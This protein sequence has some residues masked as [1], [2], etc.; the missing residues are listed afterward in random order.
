MFKRV[1]FDNMKSGYTLIQT[2]AGNK[3]QQK[4]TCR[5]KTKTYQWRVVIS[6]TCYHY[7]PMEMCRS[8]PVGGMVA[9]WLEHSPPHWTVW[10]QA[11]V[12]DFA[13]SSWARHSHSASHTQG[14]V[15]QKVD[16]AI[17]WMN[18]YPVDSDCVVCFVNTYPLDSDLS[19]EECYPAFEQ[20]RPGV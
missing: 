7:Y 8:V 15:V 11:L 4:P 12:G 6:L 18:H 13:L 20:L 14:L 10:V 1:G 5:Y 19:A 17:P 3:L 2:T 16:N 9:S